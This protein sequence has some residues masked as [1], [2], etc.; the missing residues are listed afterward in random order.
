MSRLPQMDLMGA[1][2]KERLWHDM[3]RDLTSYIP[4]L[5]SDKLLM[6]CVCGRFLPQE[7]F[8]LEHIIPRQAL[9]DQ[10]VEVRR[11]LTVNQ[12]SG[13]ILLCTK[14]LRLKGRLVY[15]NGCNSWKGRFYDQPIRA[16]LNGTAIG[17][18]RR[19][20]S[21]EYI[22]ALLCVGYVAMV[23]T[24]GYQVALTSSGILSRHQFFMPHKFHND[25]PLRSQV[26]LIAPPI[27]LQEECFSLWEKP[28][29]LSIVDGSCLF[30]VGSIVVRLPVSRNPELPIAKRIKIIPA[31]YALRP[32]FRTMF[33]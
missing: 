4:E 16:I 19:R 28:F 3:R 27:K 6:C 22:I 33:D 17:N 12:R 21:N 10:P 13:N 31:K 26:V 18:P 29:T 7:H 14:P 5:N 15:A 23:S 30:C 32:D 2:L 8:S 1:S 25:M 9:A 20:F 11:R 24:Y